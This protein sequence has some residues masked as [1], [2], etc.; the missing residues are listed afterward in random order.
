M[1]ESHHPTGPPAV[2]I[3]GTS[4]GIGAACALDLDGRGWRVFAGVRKEAD[5]Q[6]LRKAASERLLPVMLDVTD[7]RSVRAAAEK[8]G[9]AVGPSGLAGLVNNAGIVVPGPLELVP[10]EKV[11]RQLEV[12]VLG[13]LAVTQAV[14][15]LLRAGRGRIVNVGSISG[16]IA[17]PYMGAYAAS[18]HALEA[19]TDVLRVELRRWGI[20]VAI[21]EPDSVA[22]PIWDKF[23]TDAGELAQAASPAV[24]RL[25]DDDLLQMRK[26]V[27][28]LDKS[29]MPVEKVVRAVRHALTARRP[30]TRYPLGWRTRL[31]V[32]AFNRIPDRLR[33]W[34]TL[35]SMGVRN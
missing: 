20:Q 25:Y 30:K 22:T 15:P 9:D 31:G 21:V 35:R 28:R 5:A 6:R 29:G 1:P 11:R 34:I 8:I 16:R 4:T 18:K 3:T 33:D 13:H 23:E 2:L 12:N 27:H 10:L 24:C 19:V 7:Q 17:P 14:L 32:W 26:A